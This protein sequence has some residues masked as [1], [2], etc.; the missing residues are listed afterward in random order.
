MA[1]TVRHRLPEPLQREP[2]QRAGLHPR[3]RRGAPNSGQSSTRGSHPASRAGAVPQPPRGWLQ[4]QPGGQGVAGFRQAALAG[5][6]LGQAEQAW[7]QGPDSRGGQ[8]WHR[9]TGG[10]LPVVMQAYTWLGTKRNH[11][12]SHPSGLRRSVYSVDKAKRRMTGGQGVLQVPGVLTPTASQ[13]ASAPVPT[14][15]LGIPPRRCPQ[16]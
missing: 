15:P 4:G 10:S 9:L 14:L 3:G 6:L 16:G 7:R 12:P 2:R 1:L 13:G 5:F 11:I 8:G